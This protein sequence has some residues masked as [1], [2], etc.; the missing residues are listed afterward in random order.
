MMHT[1]KQDPIYPGDIVL[2]EHTPGWTNAVIVGLNPGEFFYMP[3]DYQW[4]QIDNGEVKPPR[5]DID[6]DSIKFVSVMGYV[7]VRYLPGYMEWL[8]G[9]ADLRA[10][11]FVSADSIRGR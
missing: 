4:N 5:A 10:K 3:K 8:H 9:R 2:I 7:N 6:V 1:V 11:D